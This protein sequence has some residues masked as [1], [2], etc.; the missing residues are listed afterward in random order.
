MQPEPSKRK[1]L[2]KLDRRERQIPSVAKRATDAA[3]DQSLRAGIDVVLVRGGKLV[4]LMPTGQRKEIGT[5]PHRV[6]RELKSYT[7]VWKPRPRD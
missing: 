2:D 5:V 3:R 4:R 7:L 6:K 1:S